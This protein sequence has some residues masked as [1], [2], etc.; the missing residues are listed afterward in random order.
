MCKIVV[1]AFCVNLEIRRAEWPNGVSDPGP[2]VN[3]HVAITLQLLS[4]TAQSHTAQSLQSTIN[5]FTASKPTVQGYSSFDSGLTVSSS[6]IQGLQSAIN[7]IIPISVDF[8]L[9]TE[10]MI[11]KVK[12][13]EARGFGRCTVIFST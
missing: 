9:L 1:Y 8:R 7:A 6:S 4:S 10:S 13:Q 12:P 2:T 3:K 5:R 11:V